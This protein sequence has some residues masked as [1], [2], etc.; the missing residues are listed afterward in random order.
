MF[1]VMIG[2]GKILKNQ[3]LFANSVETVSQGTKNGDF[4]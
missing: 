3:E 4:F 1:L 2:I